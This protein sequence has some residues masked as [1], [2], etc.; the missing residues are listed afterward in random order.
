MKDDLILCYECGCEIEEGNEYQDPY[1]RSICEDCFDETYMYCE[2]CDDVIPR[3]DAIGINNGD[4]YVCESC[5]DNHYYR[6]DDCGDYFS[7]RYIYMRNMNLCERCSYDY[8]VCDDCGDFV[9]SDDAHFIDDGAYCDS[10]APEHALSDL[11][12]DAYYK[13]VP[14]FL[15]GCATGYYGIELEIDGGYDRRDC[16]REIVDLCG[17]RL[18]C[19][20]DGSLNNGFEIVTHPATLNYHINDMKWDKIINTALKYGFRSH[21]TTTCGLHVHASRTLFGEYEMIQ[22]LN[23]AKCI[24]LIENNFDS[25]ILPFSRRTSDRMRE[26]SRRP[27]ACINDYDNEITAINKAKRTEDDGRYQAVNLTNRN[28]VEFRFFR[29]TLN[30]ETLFAALQFIDFIIEYSSNNNLK[31]VCI[32]DFRDVLQQQATGYLK[33]YL[34]KRNI[35]KKEEECEECV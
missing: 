8:Y 3:D 30:I 5:A 31:D 14:R 27:R 29:G 33:D 17:D 12:K 19:K 34:I 26:W 32:K 22:D 9:H 7:D 6:C 28:T 16:A 35:I 2:Y 24:L 21:D 15:G 25:I 13:P 1:G 20:Y 10:C 11:I 23:I 4:F 18:Y